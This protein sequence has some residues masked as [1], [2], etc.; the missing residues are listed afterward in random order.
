MPKPAQPSVCLQIKRPEYAEPKTHALQVRRLSKY[1]DD[2]LT[3]ILYNGKSNV[4]D[5]PQEVVD[6]IYRWC[7]INKMRLNVGKCK[8]L[9]VRRKT[10]SDPILHLPSLEGHEL[11]LVASYKYLGVNLCSDFSWD[12][13]WLRVQ[14][15]ISKVPYVLKSL[16]HSGFKTSILIAVYRCYA[17]SH[18]AYS[19]PVLTSTS[20]AIKDEMSSFQSRALRIIGITRE[21]A[22]RDFNI[23]PIEQ[24]IDQVCVNIAA[25]V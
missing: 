9:S 13:Q 2:I 1:A 24:Y 14:K 3:Y 10:S 21:A 12:A 6:G 5:L 16:K 20:C 8:C 25:K 22:L 17:L 7:Q 15:S 19:A 4:N 11:E 23:V 18:F